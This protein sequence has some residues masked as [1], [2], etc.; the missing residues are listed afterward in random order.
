VLLYKMTQEVKKYNSVV[1][2]G[3]G[4]D[5]LFFGY[6]RIFKWAAEA[7]SWD[8]KEFSSRY[9][10]GAHEDWEVLEDV[11]APFVQEGGSPL[12]IVARFFQLAHLHGLLRRVDNSTMRCSV[13]ARVPFIDHTLVERMS[14]VPASYRMQD[15]VVKAP[16]K[17]IFDSLIPDE[18]LTRKKIGFPVPLEEIFF[19]RVSDQGGPK[20]DALDR[21][22]KFN[23]EQLTGTQFSI[24]DL[25][26]S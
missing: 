12:D 15:G 18:I 14:G 25:K 17:R 24:E 19:G 7:K 3:E 16:L 2:S 5:E 4:A 6:D 1:L 26:I 9:S 22:L 23:L 21:W 20:R 10:Y 8:I 11:M 13:E